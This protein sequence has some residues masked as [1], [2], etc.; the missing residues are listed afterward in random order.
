[1]LDNFFEMT[2]RKTTLRFPM[3]KFFKLKEKGTTVKTEIMAGLTTFFAMVY[4]LMVNPEIFSNPL[5]DGTNPLG[6]SYGAVYIATS[7][8]AIIGTLLIGLGLADVSFATWF[9]RTILFQLILMA[10]SL[11]FLMIAIAVGM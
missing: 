5:T 6:V 3:E 8:S 4:I 9:K 11:G 1:M 2:A 7:V 10:L